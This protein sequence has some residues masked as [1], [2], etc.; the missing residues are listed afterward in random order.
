MLPKPSILTLIRQW[1]TP[2]VFLNHVRL[3]WLHV[4]QW[5]ASSSS[6]RPIPI[7]QPRC[8]PP[9]KQPRFLE[10]GMILAR[11][12]FFT[13]LARCVFCPILRAKSIHPTMELVDHNINHRNCTRP[14]AVTISGDIF[15]GSKGLRAVSIIHHQNPNLSPSPKGEQ[16]TGVHCRPSYRN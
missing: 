7:T 8:L 4:V 16:N 2:C 11:R 14:T 5:D 15:A 10:Y 6:S 9:E 1:S 12:H 3:Q 13:S